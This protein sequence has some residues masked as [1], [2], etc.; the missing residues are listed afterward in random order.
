MLSWLRRLFS[1]RRVG[2]STPNEGSDAG[3]YTRPAVWE[4]VLVTARLL[5][6]EGARYLLVG[7]YALAA[8]GYVRM[9]EDIDIAVSPDA[10]NAR[11]WVAA[12]SR[13]PDGAAAG[14]A[15][16]TDPF[17]GDYLHAI[18]IND[19]F[20]VD[21]LPAVA[22]VPFHELDRHVEWMD[23]DGE[24]IPVL[25]LAGLLKTKQGVRPKDQ[26]DAEILRRA[27]ERLAERGGGG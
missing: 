10:A 3:A 9:T 11:R 19:E 22:G 26:A 25:D 4:D 15:L 17:Q 21:V 18:R 23:L 14:L 13:L 2:D 1:K 8:H 24:R 12:L 6:A 27:I 7:G 20:T 5:N 16:E